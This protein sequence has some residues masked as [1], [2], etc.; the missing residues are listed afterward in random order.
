MTKSKIKVYL[1]IFIS[2]ISLLFFSTSFGQNSKSKS[3]KNNLLPKEITLNPN[4]IKIIDSIYVFKNGI[5]KL[6]TIQ[7]FELKNGILVSG[8]RKYYVNDTLNQTTNDVFDSNGN[9]IESNT[10]LHFK[11]SNQIF[12]RKLDEYGNIIQLTTTENNKVN[13]LEYRNA[14]E[15]N[16]LVDVSAISK[17]TGD[18][19]K[20]TSFKYDSRGNLI[21]EWFKS[22]YLDAK[23]LYQYNKT[24]Q[25][26][27]HKHI[28][29]GVLN[30]S[31]IY[32][33]DK[34]LLSKKEW[35]EDAFANPMI[36]NYYYNEKQQLILEK[37]E[38]LNEKTE[39]KNFDSFDNWQIK[40]Q[41]SYK[42][43]NRL[44]KR[45]FINR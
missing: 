15:K 28:R 27:L 5:Q 26:I 32:H 13:I 2:F 30:D 4:T 41:Y 44:I 34:G 16:K 23:N 25:V 36:K 37:Q 24:N 17:K 19:L 29:N 9:C 33:Y 20:K 3:I 39:Y 1:T 10:L 7:L 31:I 35:Y 42:N 45:V 11:N 12:E 22:S 21:E 18:I 6:E 40:E 8:N 14:Y 38:D 43:I